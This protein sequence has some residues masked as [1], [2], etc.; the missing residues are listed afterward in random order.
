MPSHPPKPRWWDYRSR[1]SNWVSRS[2]WHALILS[3]LFVAIGVWMVLDPGGDRPRTSPAEARFFGWA[4]IL[5]FGSTSIV[6]ATRIVRTRLGRGVTVAR[7]ED[8]FHQS[9]DQ[10]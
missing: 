8:R 2:N 1:V 5:F 6:L 7:S 4:G 9:G 10:N 3:L